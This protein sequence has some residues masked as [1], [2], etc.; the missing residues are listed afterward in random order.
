MV[1]TCHVPFITGISQI[2]F[3]YRCE[4]RML[5]LYAPS[6]LYA[7]VIASLMHL[8]YPQPAW[9]SGLLSI[10]VLTC[11]ILELYILSTISGSSEAQSEHAL[12]AMLILAGQSRCTGKGPASRLVGES[13]SPPDVKALPAP[14]AI[15]QPRRFHLRYRENF[16]LARARCYLQHRTTWPRRDSWLCSGRSTT[17]PLQSSN[18]SSPLCF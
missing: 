8:A 5:Y 18:A 4:S 17:S 12:L 15:S 3:H 10:F 7:R 14:L 6:V 16:V 9:F 2:R 11:S 1:S 13:P